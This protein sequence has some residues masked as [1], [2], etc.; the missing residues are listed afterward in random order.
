MDAVESGL[1]GLLPRG[2]WTRRGFVSLLSGH[3]E[4]I[5]VPSPFPWTMLLVAVR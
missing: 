5:E 4:V 1:Q 3:G 2:Q